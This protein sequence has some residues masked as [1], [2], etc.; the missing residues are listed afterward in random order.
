MRADG[1]DAGFAALPYEGP[2][3]SLVAALKFGRL[4]IA[5]E[6][7]GALIAARA[8]WQLPTAI[9]P[10]PAAPLRLASRG[11]DPAAELAAALSLATGARVEAPL[12]RRD[13]RRQRGR[14]RSERIA[15]PPA[16][17]AAGA[18]PAE[19]LL[20]DDVATTGATLDA[21]AAALRSAGSEVVLAGAL[22]AVPA[23][24]PSLARARH[25]GVA[26]KRPRA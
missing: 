9:V 8:P 15:S 5:A 24:R 19:V 14:R 6:L 13:L 26:W 12:R 7:G 17:V 10:V 2:A 23:A 4:L 21:C 22:A 16:V 11:F 1:V 20:I 25:G 3:R 18:A